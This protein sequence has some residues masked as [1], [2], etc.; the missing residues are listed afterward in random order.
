MS[1]TVDRI[2]GLDL[3]SGIGG[4]TLALRDY[5]KT[6]AYC[7]ADRHAQSVLLS[8]MGDGSIEPAPIWDDVTT[9][10]GPMFDHPIDIIIGGFPCQD[11]SVAGNGSGLDGKRSG[12]VFEIFRLVG[13]IKP[14]FVFL[15]NVSAI[16][17]RGGERVVKELAG[18]GY[19]CRWDMLSAFDVG[20]P[21]KRER[22]FLLGYANGGRQVGKLRNLPSQNAVKGIEGRGAPN[23]P[24]NASC[25]SSVLAVNSDSGR[26]HDEQEPRGLEYSQGER[27]Q[28]E[29]R[30]GSDG[31]GADVA[32]A[33][34]ER[35]RRRAGPQ[36]VKDGWGQ[37]TDS[38]WWSV[39]PNVGRMANGVPLRVDRLKRLGNAVVPLQAKTAFERLMNL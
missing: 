9:L 37:S 19:D 8:R 30:H 27:G 15:E 21:H 12:L 36:S 13:E 34:K 26:Q 16:R 14:A 23:I 11:I 32:D 20:A 39:E 6:V 10:S 2:N 1:N 35:W 38:G 33:D 25:E 22:W 7:E 28:Q 24:G 18:L 5:I 4:N 17:T 31:L 3:F 29:R